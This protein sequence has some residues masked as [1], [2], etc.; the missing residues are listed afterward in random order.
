MNNTARPARNLI[1]ICPRP[2]QLSAC[3]NPRIQLLTNWRQLILFPPFE[4]KTDARAGAA[5]NN[6]ILE[7]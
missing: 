4:S 7:T 5:N 2:R 6:L 3:K 1:F